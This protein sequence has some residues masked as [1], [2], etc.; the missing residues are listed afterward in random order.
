MQQKHNSEISYE[1]NN[2]K[3]KKDGNKKIKSRYNYKMSSSSRK[4]IKPFIVKKH[5]DKN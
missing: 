1:R 3:G 2:K 5:I 4:V